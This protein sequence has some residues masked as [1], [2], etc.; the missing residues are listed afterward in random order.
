M[1]KGKGQR[2]EMT[3]LVVAVGVLVAAVG[4][5]VL[6]SR[7]A[8]PPP[9]PAPIGTR[10]RAPAAPKPQGE[11]SPVGRDPFATRPATVEQTRPAAEASEPGSKPK[12]GQ[13]PEASPESK[14]S[15]MTLVGIM[16][17]PPSVAIIHKGTRRYYVKAGQT[18]SGYTVAR[19]SADRVVLS[20]GTEQITL[21]LRPPAEED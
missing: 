12:P 13:R 15:E 8:A 14:S 4:L 18:V 7:P 11:K 17:G 2:H 5:F 21:L 19:V 20:Q 10:E 16:T 9:P 6:R 1:N 3:V